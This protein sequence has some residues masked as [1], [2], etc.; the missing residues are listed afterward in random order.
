[1]AERCEILKAI[2]DNFDEDSRLYKSRA[3]EMEYETT[4]KYIHKFLKPDA[5]IIEI[6]AGTGQYSVRLAK[7][8][9]EVCAVELLDKNIEILKKNAS[10][11]KNIKVLQGDAVNLCDFSNESFDLTLVLGPM[12]HLYDRSEVEKAID[13]AL[14]VTKKGGV[15]L[16]AFLSI[17]AIMMSQ[18]MLS[19]FE[20]GIK[21]NFDK[22][23]NGIHFAQQGFTGYFV[24][25]FEK[26]FDCKN[27]EYITTVATDGSLELEEKNPK[28]NMSDHNFNLYR[29]YHFATCEKRELLGSSSHLLY[30][31]K[32][33]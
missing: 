19:N 31:C 27:A 1:M 20:D 29:K 32:K 26:L 3:G 33:I 14:R 18:Y 6:G 10:N 7:E 30:I 16:Y 4:M 15:I 24:D 2:Y 17:H 22:D 21:E 5:K 9:Y 25:D 13:E 28:F 8:G 23:F 12:Y 11:V